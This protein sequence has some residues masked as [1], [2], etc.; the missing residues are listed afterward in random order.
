MPN[1]TSKCCVLQRRM[2]PTCLRYSME[3]TAYMYILYLLSNSKVSVDNCCS[4]QKC[5]GVLSEHTIDNLDLAKTGFFS[6]QFMYA[7]KNTM[8]TKML[9]RKYFATQ[10]THYT[11][12][13]RRNLRLTE[14]RRYKH[15]RLPIK[16]YTCTCTYI[17]L[18]MIPKTPDRF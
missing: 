9:E 15:Q 3:N 12:T 10:L 13:S 1:P 4:V 7:Q 18:Y 14:M 5:I 6:T 11:L 16:D 17:D 2:G 8:R